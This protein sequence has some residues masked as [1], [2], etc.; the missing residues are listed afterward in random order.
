[1]PSYKSRISQKH[2]TETNWNK[3]TNFV[4]LAGELIVYDTDDT[5]N[6]PRV[7]IGDGNTGLESLPFLGE[8]NTIFRILNNFPEGSYYPG[9]PI[10]FSCTLQDN[11]TS[12]SIDTMK[13]GDLCLY[14]NGVKAYL[15]KCVDP[16]TENQFD[17]SAVVL[18]STDDGV[19][20]G[21]RISNGSIKKAKLDSAVQ[22]S[23]D[24]A[25]N[26]LP[27]SGGTLTGNL[28]GKYITGTRLQVTNNNH[29]SSAATKVCVQDRDGWIYHRTP[30]ELLSDLGAASLSA[31]QNWSAEQHFNA[32]FSALNNNFRFGDTTNIGMEL[33][34]QDGTAGTPYIDFHTDGKSS[35]DYNSRLLATG[36]Q[37]QITASGGL[38]LNG[39]DVLV[40]QIEELSFTLN[41]EYFEDISTSGGAGKQTGIWKISGTDIFII[42]ANLTVKKAINKSTGSVWAFR[43]FNAYGRKS[44]Q[45][46]WKRSAHYVIA[47]SRINHGGNAFWLD[48]FDDMPTVQNT[49]LQSTLVFYGYQL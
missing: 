18:S 20:S 15:L 34:R 45:S 43:E 33:G 11:M 19:V 12:P 16:W 48:P 21:S 44:F 29:L 27:I 4:P 9:D 2:D 6:V 17:W 14:E 22:T 30:T 32:G 41:T 35:T 47:G 10:S 36:N 5:H 37:L 1:M 39:K 3:A 49:T 7:K 25:D 38:S 28:E 8:G 42:N 13:A 31:S 24:K 40:N 46:I 23:L 26:A